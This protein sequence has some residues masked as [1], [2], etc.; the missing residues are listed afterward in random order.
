MK[1]TFK[2]VAAI[3][4]AAL[5]CVSTMVPT[6]AADTAKCPGENATHDA[7][8]CTFVQVSEQKATCTT[9][10]FVTGRCTSC[11]KIFNA[12]RTDALGHDWN[13]IVPATC[14][15]PSTKTCKVCKTEVT[16]SPKL[17]HLYTAYSV[18]GGV[19]KVGERISRECIYC[20]LED[21]K[22]IGNE[23]HVFALASY[24]EPSNCVTDGQA[25][26]T[27]VVSGCGF[28]KIIPIKAN[29]TSS[30]SAHKYVDWKVV[31]G[32]AK[33]P[34]AVTKTCTTS[35]RASIICLYCND[36]KIKSLGKALHTYSAV[37]AEKP[38]T[39]TTQ[40]FQA[41]KYCVDC[42][43]YFTTAGVATTYADLVVPAHHTNPA[44]LTI[45]IEQNPTCIEDG[46][47]YVT[48][49]MCENYK[50][51][52]I[53][54]PKYSGHLYYAN[55][56]KKED[57]INI[58]KA[59]GM[60]VADAEV[61]TVWAELGKVNFTSVGKDKVWKNYIPA[62]CTS[63]AL[64]SW[65]CLNCTKNEK[66]NA[67]EKTVCDVVSTV[68]PVGEEY[69]KL[70]HKFV[71][72]YP[73]TNTIPGTAYTD[74]PAAT[75]T[76]TG[77][78]VYE[79]VNEY[80]SASNV[81]VDCK[82]TQTPIVMNPIGHK[83]E[84]VD[85]ITTATG[86]FTTTAATCRANG[87]QCYQCVNGCNGT[88]TETLYSTGTEHKWAYVDST[89]DINSLKCGEV[90]TVE[91]YCLEANCPAALE[92]KAY[93]VTGP[94]HDYYDVTIAANL[95]AIKLLNKNTNPYITNG[96]GGKVI[97]EYLIAGNC[98]RN[99]TYKLTCK[100]CDMFKSFEI[101]EGFKQGHKKIYVSN[102]STA[103]E[104]NL[105][106]GSNKWY[107][108]NL[109]CDYYM[110]EGTTT[111]PTTWGGRDTT[112]AANHY[113]W[114]STTNSLVAVTY[115]N[116]PDTRISGATSSAAAKAIEAPVDS[117]GI[118]IRAVAIEG[119][120]LIWVYKYTA[121]DHTEATIASGGFYCVDCK[122]YTGEDYT[123]IPGYVTGHT[124]TAKTTVS[125]T[126]KNYGY[127]LY[128]CA[129]GDSYQSG[130]TKIST[131]RYLFIDS[132]DRATAWNNLTSAQKEGRA[133]QRSTCAMSGYAIDVCLD[134]G[135]TSTVSIA[136]TGH[137]NK[138]GQTLT[139]SCLDEPEDR[140][141]ANPGCG[142]KIEKK[143]DDVNG[144][145]KVCGA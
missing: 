66:N 100:K 104:C 27:C 28:S 2:K 39:C 139:T 128:E 137:R 56:T 12:S 81:A 46:W 7:N 60:V 41:Y 26:Y 117:N 62:N 19:C 110:P 61:E 112:Y 135:M 38:A 133:F 70:N 121:K 118:V 123:T 84:K 65:I 106:G 33:D 9:E 89:F 40:G 52:R 130:Y 83:W 16:V 75:C 78:R 22:T 144:V 32:D 129:C 95:E 113:F 1:H 59:L 43:A 96:E 142:W 35:G 37:Q 21:K 115:K 29:S 108:S 97:V 74:N 90:K 71:E 3:L 18:S 31:K 72:I 145:C 111:L 93:T 140:Y 102:T 127:T 14:D 86:T 15:A 101:S 42:L 34:N 126:C 80:L 105:S 54:L 76:G 85:S 109:G 11:S 132:I 138:Y 64:V 57:K 119:T 25:K 103:A 51:Q 5:M 8:N 124:Y 125:A 44:K 63:N 67:Y 30:A 6:F 116:V 24:V 36:V 17:T 122:S 99:A 114:N 82:V 136:A 79:C 13:D 49:T 45:T 50:D 143:H 92:P 98:D 141:C 10:G 120:S 94:A 4:L 131:H 134:C 47:R 23:G 91:R 107:C 20:G 73:S 48:C 53:V 77:V 69:L 88:K 68:T 55:V 87:L 58:L